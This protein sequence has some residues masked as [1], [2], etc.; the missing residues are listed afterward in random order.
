[1]GYSLLVRQPSLTSL[2]DITQNK[3]F[4]DIRT[5]AAV[6]N[7]HLSKMRDQ[8]QDLT[9]EHTIVFAQKDAAIVELKREVDEVRTQNTEL[10]CD[11]H[12]ESNNRKLAVVCAENLTRQ[13]D[14]K[15]R[16]VITLNSRVAEL[17]NELAQEKAKHIAD[18]GANEKLR[19]ITEQCA[20]IARLVGEH[21]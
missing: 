5:T 9:A 6:Y 14:I 16:E 7:G 20:E 11:L 1:M 10:L 19:S 2:A 12:Q 17:E 3:T 15:G 8:I 4:L 13:N 21:P 18:K